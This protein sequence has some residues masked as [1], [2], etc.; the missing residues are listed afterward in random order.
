MYEEL[1]RLSYAPTEMPIE[2]LVDML[3][4]NV[5]DCR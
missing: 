5:M 1:G 3:I 4:N 2:M